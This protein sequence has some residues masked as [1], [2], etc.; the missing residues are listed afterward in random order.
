MARQK[1]NGMVCAIK[2]I[3]EPAAKVRVDWSVGKRLHHNQDY[4]SFKH[5]LNMMHQLLAIPFCQISKT[6]VCEDQLLVEVLENEEVKKEGVIEPP[7]IQLSSA[8]PTLQEFNEKTKQARTTLVKNYPQMY[9]V[10]KQ[11]AKAEITAE[12]F[13]KLTGKQQAKLKYWHPDNAT[14][15]KITKQK[16]KRTYV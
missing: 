10:V 3:E 16:Q 7:T 8:L 11:E 13:D 5:A 12:Q 6:K 2:L 1:L 14:F 15:Q 9:G 4:R